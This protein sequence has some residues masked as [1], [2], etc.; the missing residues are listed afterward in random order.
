[1]INTVHVYIDVN[2]LMMLS[3]ILEFRCATKTVNNSEFLANKY[4][5]IS[6]H[7]LIVFSTFGIGKKKVC[8]TND[9]I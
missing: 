2:L 7:L 9:D 6:A 8:Y 1:M 3:N 4:S 5:F